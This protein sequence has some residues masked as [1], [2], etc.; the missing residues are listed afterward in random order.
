MQSIYFQCQ[1]F[2]KIKLIFFG[3]AA[4]RKLKEIL[5]FSLRHLKAEIIFLK[6]I[7]HM[8]WSTVMPSPEI[9]SLKRTNIST[10]NNKG[11]TRLGK[12]LSHLGSD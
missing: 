11:L 10:K 4:I 7:T 12:H 5:T 2:E 8:F 3:K 6:N 9:K 1:N